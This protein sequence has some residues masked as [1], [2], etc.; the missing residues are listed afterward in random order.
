MFPEYEAKLQCGSAYVIQNIKVVKNH[1]EYKVSTIS[2]LVYLMKTI[3]VKE[4]DRPEI[5][6][7]VHVITQF[8]V[9]PR[10][11]LVGTCITQFVTIDIMIVREEYL[12]LHCIVI[13]K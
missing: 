11:T 6:P 8:G 12:R 5:P 3:F 1:S 4:I 10:D 7:N 13:F 9:A 2:F